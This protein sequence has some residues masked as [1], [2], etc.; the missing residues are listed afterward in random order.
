MNG[1]GSLFTKG[2]KELVSA[3][4]KTIDDN[5]TNDEERSQLKNNLTNIVT[6][7][8]NELS[9]L[10]RDVIVAEAKGNFL[11]RSWRPIIML[12]MG[13]I[14]ACKWFGYTNSEIPLELEQELMSL[15]KLGIGGYI[16][17]RTLEKVAKNVTQNIDMPFLKRKDRKTE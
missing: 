6:S 5:V 16:G 1:I 7:K 15:L 3:I 9:S 8:L 12:L 10:S 2:A 13:F 14:L 4:G 11:Q 17:G